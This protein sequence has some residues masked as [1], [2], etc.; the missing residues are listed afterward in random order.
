MKLKTDVVKLK[1][2]VWL[3]CWKIRFDAKQLMVLSARCIVEYS[4]C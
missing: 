4:E 2:L 3:Y 1:Y